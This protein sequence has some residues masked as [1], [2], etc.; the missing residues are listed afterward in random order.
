M[1]T[2]F[3][4]QKPRLFAHR[5]ASGEAPENTVAAFQRATELGIVYA[6]LDVHA[7]HDGHVVVTHDATIERTTNGQ[8]QIR[9]LSL[10]ELQQFDAGYHFSLDQGQ[11]FPFRGSGV[12]IPTLVEVL[13][14]FPTL[15]IT[16]EIKQTEPAIEESVLA[17]V[18]SCGREDHV[19]I[20]SEH[21]AVLARV[22]GLAP[23]M[24]TNFG[25]WEVAEFIRRVSTQEFADYQ[26]PGHAFQIPVEFHGIS[27]VNEHT[28]AA[29][30]AL[31]CE[32]HV[33]T[34]DEPQEMEQLLDLGV[35]GIMS[36]FPGRL[37]EVARRRYS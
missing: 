7:T 28:V 21:D 1:H 16:I 4:G 8:G 25:Y 13:Q 15:R 10:A 22:R 24:A 20:A 5:G 30:H 31:N 14:R 12:Q 23:E 2:F 27:L 6:E 26:P 29:A 37:L 9:A 19:V 18:R 3:R 35:D 32:M 17:A 36:N 11:T 34:V 33:W